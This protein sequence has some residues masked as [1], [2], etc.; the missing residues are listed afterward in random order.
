MLIATLCTEEHRLFSNFQIYEVYD[1]Q[2]V[3]VD[4]RSCS[5]DHGDKTFPVICLYNKR[6]YNFLGFGPQGYVV[7]QAYLLTDYVTTISSSYLFIG[8]ESDH[9]Q[10]LSLTN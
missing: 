3:D 10:C 4:D 7:F 6:M 5:H 2:F 1:A 8:P 9:W